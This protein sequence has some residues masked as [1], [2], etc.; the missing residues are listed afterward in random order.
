MTV[1]HLKEKF[2]ES[3]SSVLPITAIVLILSVTITPMPL[4]VML[5]F[6]FGA[7]MLIV[8]MSFFTLG[9]DMALTPFGESMGV[10][11]TKSKK[12]GLLLIVSLVIGMLVT[13]AE[14]D[15][16]VLANQV[17]SIP[18]SVLIITVALGV[19]LF[20]MLA[21][22]RM[23]LK[24]PLR[25]VLIALYAIVFILASFAPNEFIPVAFDSGGVTTGPI[26]V[27]FILALGVGVA[28]IRSDKKGHDDS[29]GLVALSSIGPIIA[30]L[31]LGIVYKP[32]SAAYSVFEVVDYS[33]TK[34]II[35]VFLYD[36]PKYISEVSLA[37]APIFL[38]F[39]LYNM[40]THRFK[41]HRLGR[42]VIGFLYT[43]V[44]LVL[45]LTG[46]NVGFMPA[47][48]FIGGA[49]AGLDGRMSYLLIPLGMLMGWFIVAAE[50]SVHVL[51]RQVEEMT[52]GAVSQKAMNLSLSI[53]VAVSTGLAM[54]RVLTSI[55]I[56]WFLIP[57]YALAIFLSF[58]APP[59][60]TGIAFD[61]GGV[62]SGP[63]TATFLLPFAM[64]ACDALGGNMMLD[65]FGVVAMVAMTPLITI[66][67]LGI[68]Y[69]RRIVR[70]KRALE[71]YNT[72]DDDI[73]DYL[74]AT[75]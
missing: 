63:M 52:N 29:F 38:V 12:V 47:G 15:L 57:G 1:N 67:I 37:I 34:E 39:L 13:I 41:G 56:F 71:V 17:P 58:K 61:S 20:L 73:I 45:F 35:R 6:I 66:Q 27:P 25:Y 54:I 64:G 68:Y 10:S 42:T 23:F 46:V 22:I 5:L 3:L 60:F 51:N 7:M 19:G 44:G 16:Q 21:M 18:N 43:F 2:F 36:T 69:D 31:L 33:D 28:S 32:D 49:I 11:M 48:T 30:V 40:I 9:A 4:G 14:P 26:T 62:A 8:G 75:I 59:I 53:G 70:M 55:S 24:I 74:E 72:L 50:P 65:A